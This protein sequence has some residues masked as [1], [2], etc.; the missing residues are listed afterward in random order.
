MYYTGKTKSSARLLLKKIIMR[1]MHSFAILADRHYFNA[2]S[3]TR[4]AWH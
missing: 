4:Y 2:G 3:T 1:L